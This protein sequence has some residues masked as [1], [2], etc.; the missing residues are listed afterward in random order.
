MSD[1]PETRAVIVNAT[2]KDS[3]HGGG[4]WIA[5][6]AD[7]PRIL[8]A[9]DGFVDELYRTDAIPNAAYVA[10]RLSGLQEAVNRLSEI[11]ASRKQ[12][13]TS[14]VIKSCARH[15]A[16]LASRPASPNVRVVTVERLEYWADATQSGLVETEIRAII[17]GQP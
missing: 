14:E 9:P 1:A 16:A 13:Q 15:I 3:L 2:W 7:G 10:G 11:V 4:W 12:G 8:L 5:K 17:G 6:D